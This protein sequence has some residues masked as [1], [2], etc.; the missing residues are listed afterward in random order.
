[1]SKIFLTEDEKYEELK[2]HIETLSPGDGVSNS[3]IKRI[4]NVG[5]HFAERL[6]EK[7]LK[8]DYLESYKQWV[9]KTVNGIRTDGHEITLYRVPTKNKSVLKKVKI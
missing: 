8:D 1:M 4:I 6:I 3:Y 7:L 9:G 5:Y 2:K